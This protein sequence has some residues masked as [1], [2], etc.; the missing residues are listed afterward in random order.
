ML[1]TTRDKLKGQPAMSSL[2]EALTK[3]KK[4]GKLKPAKKGKRP[5]PF[6]KGNTPPSANDPKGNGGWDV[7]KAGSG[8]K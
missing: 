8:W 5:N 3:F 1:S 2:S 7:K 6:D 4:K